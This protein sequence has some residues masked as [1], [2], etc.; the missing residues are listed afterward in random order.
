[1]KQEII[2][3]YKQELMRIRQENYAGR[4]VLYTEQLSS[5][6]LAPGE[7]NSV[8]LNTSRIL[9]STDEIAF[10]NTAEIVEV[11]KTGG[12]T[13]TPVS[14]SKRWQDEGELVFVTPPTGEDRGYIEYIIIAISSLT[15]GAVAIYFINKK[16]IKK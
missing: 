1:M 7:E 13:I 15:L 6:A 14:D 16:V 12:P 3:Q 4:I 8:T 9:A 10:E 11:D 2:E 5:K